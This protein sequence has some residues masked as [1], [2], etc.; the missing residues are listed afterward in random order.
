LFAFAV[1]LERVPPE[2]VHS[3]SFGSTVTMMQLAPVVLFRS[4]RLSRLS[5][6]SA[7]ASKF[8]VASWRFV[9]PW[10]AGAGGPSAVCLPLTDGNG[11]KSF[12]FS[13]K[14]A[15]AATASVE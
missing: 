13:L 15:S 10:V 6:L 9:L 12:R 5:P 14:S 2:S 1:S 3:S 11:S 7:L 4:V 8:F